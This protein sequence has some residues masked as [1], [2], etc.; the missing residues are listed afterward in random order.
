MDEP[1]SDFFVEDLAK[2]NPP[3]KGVA[4]ASVSDPSE[5]RG[6]VRARAALLREH[7]RAL[8]EDDGTMIAQIRGTVHQGP[9]CG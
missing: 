2:T 4:S 6:A 9:Q 3:P 8:D 7:I 1:F 5:L